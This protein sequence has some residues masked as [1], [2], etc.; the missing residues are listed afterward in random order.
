MAI[1]HRGPPPQPTVLRL[2]RGNPRKSKVRANEPQPLLDPD[3]PDPP[4]H[5]TGYAADEWWR[6]APELYRLGLLTM[7]DHSVLAAYCV[8][9][10]R[11]CEAEEVIASIKA[12]NPGAHGLLIT[13][14]GQPVDNPIVKQSRLAA[15]AM[16]RYAAEFGFSPAARARIEMGANAPA[17]AGKFDG[18]L[19]G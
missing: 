5:V 4:P 6:V 12:N 16:V 15:E 11:W 10:G 14:N 13:R 17:R 7:V 1:G 2:L 19:A 8:A 3:V 18:L 9:Y